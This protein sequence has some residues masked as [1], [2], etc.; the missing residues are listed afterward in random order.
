[1]KTIKSDIWCYKLI[2]FIDNCFILI[3]HLSTHL[4][5]PNHPNAQ[6]LPFYWYF[7]DKTTEVVPDDAVVNLSLL[8][9]EQYKPHRSDYCLCLMEPI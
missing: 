2:L 3:T 4:K 8:A 9:H 5:H 1:M 6:T 7:K